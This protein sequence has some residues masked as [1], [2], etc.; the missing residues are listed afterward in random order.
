MTLQRWACSRSRRMSSAWASRARP[1]APIRARPRG[2]STAGAELMGGGGGEAVE[3]GQIV[4]AGQHQLG[5]DEGIGELPGYL[6]DLP[7]IDADIADRQQQREPHAD[8]VERR[9][10]QLLLLRPWQRIV[11]EHEDGRAGDGEAG[12]HQRH[13]R[14]Q[15]RR[16]NQHRPGEQE[17]KRVLQAPRQEQQHR[18]LDDV[19]R[20]QRCRVLRLQA[21]V[22]PEPQPQHHVHGAIGGDDGETG[23]ERHFEIEAVMDHQHRRRLSQHRKPAQAHQRVEAHAAHGMVLLLDAEVRHPRYRYGFDRC[24][25]ARYRS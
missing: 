12:E 4:L 9:Q 17:R 24:C 8:H 18:E 1:R 2:W 23:P 14:R 13:A 11:D 25:G 20:E 3:L 6:D 19:E 22:P 15:R 16:R 7:R 5:G 21:L 10:L